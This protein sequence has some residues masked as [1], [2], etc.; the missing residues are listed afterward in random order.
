M[1]LKRGGR[2]NRTNCLPVVQRP[3]IE[4][5]EARVLL[6]AAAPVLFHPDYVPGPADA[7]STVAGLTPAQVRKAYGFDQLSFSNG[8][9]AADGSGQTVAIVDAYDDPTIV[10]DLGVFDAQF[11]LPA[12]PSI[13]V[14]NQSGGSTLPTPDAGWA[15]EIALDVEWAHAMAPKANI[16]L[17]EANAADDSLYAAVDYARHAP[18]VSVVSMSWGG[19]EFFQFNPGETNTELSLDA[20]FTT[21]AGH[22]GVTFVASAGDTG[23]ASGVQYPSSSPNVMSVGGTSLFLQNDGS[24]LTET[25]WSG[26]NGGYSQIEREPSYQAGVQATGFRSDPDVSY[27]ADP[28]TGVALYDSFADPF[29]GVSAGWSVIGGTSAGAPQW[30]ALIALADQGRSLAGTGSLDGPA[31]TLPILY[32]LYQSPGSPNYLDYTTNFYDI[33]SGGGGRIHWRWGFGNPSQP[34]NAGYDTA[35][36]LGSPKVPSVVTALAGSIVTGSSTTNGTPGSGSGGNSQNNSLPASPVSGL[37]MGLPTSVLGGEKAKLTIRLQDTSNTAFTGPVTVTVYASTDPTVSND[38]ATVTTLSIPKL[39][40]KVGQAKT[41]K[42]KFNYPSTLPNNNY[43]IIS[44]VSAAGTNTAP[45]QSATTTVAIEGPTVDLSA[46]FASAPVTVTAGKN[47]SAQLSIENLGNV[48]PSG[49]ATLA[50]Y[51]STDQTLDAS[52]Q[53]ITTIPGVK[54]KIKPGKFSNLHIRFV[55]PA[56]LTPGKY[57]LIAVLT[58]ATQPADANAA[59]NQAVAATI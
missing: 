19:S 43:Y 40:L 52:D 20:L 41:A 30:S 39:K 59:N 17:V 31:Q 11:G 26:T 4:P 23:I 18:G 36:G 37:L 49:S 25:A 7:T 51:A 54:V 33:Q 10:N 45:S 6:S 5:L 53:L 55:A 14:V 13:N 32:S 56:N 2:G 1:P 16:L 8:A 35:T 50:L 29:G 9:V 47:S 21:P 3:P 44:S 24:Y 46:R 22:Q 34:A 28:S 15:G 57:N 27:I 58:A 42:L 48:T 12:P 38:D